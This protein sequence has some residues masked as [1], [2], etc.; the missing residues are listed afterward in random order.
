MKKVEMEMGL[1]ILVGLVQVVRR[2]LAAR[3]RGNENGW[4]CHQTT[5][6]SGLP[7]TT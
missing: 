6:G 5:S 1:E 7:V 4:G 3:Q 2:N